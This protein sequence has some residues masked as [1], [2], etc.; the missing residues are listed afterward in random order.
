MCIV[1]AR[2]IDFRFSGTRVRIKLK[3]EWTFGFSKKPIIYLAG[4]NGS[5]TPE[6][7]CLLLRTEV[8]VTFATAL[9]NKTASL[10]IGRRAIASATPA[11]AAAEL[12]AE[13]KCYDAMQ[14]GM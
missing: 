4:P 5:S 11:A 1:H 14:H 12:A 10:E 9:A 8:D 6:H 2:H 13:S 3:G 7:I